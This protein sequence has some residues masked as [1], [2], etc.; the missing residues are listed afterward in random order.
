VI[1]DCLKLIEKSRGEK[2]DI[3]AIPP[4]DEE[5]IQEGV[6]RAL[7]SGVLSVRV[8]RD[9]RPCCAVQAGT[10][11]RADGAERALPAGSDGDDRRLRRAQVAAAEGEYMAAGALRGF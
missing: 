6:S 11:S 8:E 9:A 1:D 5:N 3:E 4:D 7:T 10:G 2:V